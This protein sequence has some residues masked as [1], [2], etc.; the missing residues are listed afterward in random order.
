MAHHCS[1]F[2]TEPKQFLAACIVEFELLPEHFAVLSGHD[3]GSAVG[4]QQLEAVV[5]GLSVEATAQLVG[6]CID[7]HAAANFAYE[8]IHRRGHNAVVDWR[9]VAVK[10]AKTVIERITAIVNKRYIKPVMRCD[11]YSQMCVERSECR[12]Q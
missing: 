10:A 1:L 4:A 7:F 3:Y 2:A 8:D 11:T 12:R 9:R 5:V 6:V